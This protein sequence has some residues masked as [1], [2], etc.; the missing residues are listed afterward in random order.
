MRAPRC[1]SAFPITNLKRRRLR[2]QSSYPLFPRLRPS[3]S[4]LPP[5]L[6]LPRA[7]PSSCSFSIFTSRSRF[8]PCP[9]PSPPHPPSH[10]SLFYPSSLPPRGRMATCQL[11]LAIA[12]AYLDR[13]MEEEEEEEEEQK[14][15]KKVEEERDRRIGSTGAAPRGTSRNPERTR[16]GNDEIRAL[17]ISRRLR[18]FPGSKADYCFCRV[19]CTE[20]S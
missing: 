6:P 11:Q 7:G 2:R 8:L 16:Y 17:G 4:P 10:R 15:K 9:T 3:T 20:S 19:N 1:V 18:R 5:T 12:A 13:G 14:E